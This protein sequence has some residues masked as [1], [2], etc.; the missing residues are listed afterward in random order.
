MASF[1]FHQT[2]K[3]KDHLQHM[4]VE[5]VTT[6]ADGT[7][8]VACWLADQ[9]GQPQHETFPAESLEVV[10]DYQPRPR[11]RRRH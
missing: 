6:A 4:K 7:E 3:R 5:Q 2:V 9:W 1:A 11:R 10:T 8:M